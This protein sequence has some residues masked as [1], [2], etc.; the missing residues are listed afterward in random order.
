MIK[1]KKHSVRDNFASLLFVATQHCLSTIYVLWLLYLDVI[2]F[3]EY[4]I[5]QV[6]EHKGKM[7]RNIS[8]KTTRKIKKQS[9]IPPVIV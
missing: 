3:I 7:G 6:S 1:R 5:M 8:Q 4:N 9:A 2:N